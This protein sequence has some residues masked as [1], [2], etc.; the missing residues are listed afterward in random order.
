MIFAG[1]KNHKTMNNEEIGQLKLRL[2]QYE[3]T[4]GIVLTQ[5]QARYLHSLLSQPTQGEGEIL[6]ELREVIKHHTHH[7]T[8]E[9]N[10]KWEVIEVS[11]I[12]DVLDNQLH[13]KAECEGEI[14]PECGK[15]MNEDY[16]PCCSLDCW[17][18]RFE[19]QPQTLDELRAE[20]TRQDM[21]D[22][23]EYVAKEIEDGSFFTLEQMLEQ[24]LTGK[25]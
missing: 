5:K 6:K 25:E 1:N 11:D 15:P 21:I 19:H 23:A 20:F 12:T 24:K 13:P 8:D 7:I 22:F 3:Y 17:T 9:N 10:N 18:N 2:L 16:A 14:C 4:D